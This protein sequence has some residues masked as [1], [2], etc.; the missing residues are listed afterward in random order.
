MIRCSLIGANISQSKSPAFHNYVAQ[1]KGIDFNYNLSE[2]NS[3]DKDDFF[4]KLALLKKKGLNALNI[5]FPYKE[6]AIEA[7]DELDDSAKLT[8]AANILLFKENKLKAFNTDFSGFIKAYH[9]K[10]NQP[11]GKVIL[12]GCGGVGKA[13]AFA[14]HQLKASSIEL[15]DRD[16][17]KAAQLQ[18][19]LS[20]SGA[21]AKCVTEEELNQSILAAD[22]VI[23]CTPL[24]HYSMPGSAIP[25]ELLNRQSWIFDAV[26][27]P[28]E[29]EFIKA[30][31]KARLEVISGFDLFFYQAIDAFELFTNEKLTAAEITQ[32]HQYIFQQCYS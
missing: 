7:A 15:F 19:L 24:G 25:L 20:Q 6:F 26:Y 11:P 23:N 27:T 31:R 10:R 8:Q 1:Q 30:A 29:T 22:G 4:E 5:T 12:I 13:I 14:L 3:C 9:S 18:Q 16:A 17:D 21:H 2:V 28:L 32:Y